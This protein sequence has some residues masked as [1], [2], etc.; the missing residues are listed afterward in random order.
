LAEPRPFRSIPGLL[1]PLPGLPQTACP[2]Y[3]EDPG[4]SHPG[5]RVELQVAL[6]GT[7]HVVSIFIKFIL[8]VEKYIQNA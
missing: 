1:A 8:I 4:F 6:A 2:I 7:D 3:P 5:L